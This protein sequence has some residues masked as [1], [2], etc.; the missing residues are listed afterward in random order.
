MAVYFVDSINGS[1][2]NNGLSVDKAFKGF[3]KINET[4]LS[5]G[6]KILLKRGSVFN[7][8][9]SVKSSGEEYAPIEISAYGEDVNK[10]IIDITDDSAYGIGIFGEYTEVS[11]IEVINRRGRYGILVKAEIT[12]AVKGVSVYGCY[13]HDVWTIN[14]LGPRHLPPKS[15]PHDA[16]GICIETNREAPT[17][18]EELRI[19]HNFVENVN[20]TGIWLGGQWNNRFKNTLNW[21]ANRAP[22]MNDPWYP[23]KDVSIS[24]NTVDHAH[25]DGIVGV[26]CV[27]L[28]MEY[29]KV[30]YAN[31]MSRMGNS[32]VAL[33]SM[34]CTGALVQY[35]EVAYTGREYG[36]DGEAFDI[37]QCNIDNIYQ[38]NYSH[39][40]EGGFIL[41]CN[42]C[43]S[44]ESLY[45][46]IIR[47]NLSV[48]D[49][50]KR[51]D[52]LFNFSGPM[53]DI[54]FLNNTIYSSNKKR[55]RLFQLSDYMQIGLPQDL[56]FANNLFYS[57]S[58]DTYDN[59]EASGKLTFK[60]NLIY[61]MPRLPERENII[62][63]NIYT[64]NPVLKGEG[65]VPGSRVEVE[66]FAPLWCSSMLRLGE[67]FPEC[68][69][70]D[71][72][73]N[74]TRGKRYIGTF[75]TKDLNI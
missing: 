56:L 73:G 23:H 52:A 72:L 4:V 5:G 3:E 27:N 49:A 48:N 26:G 8:C 46:N 21:M 68:A 67:Y 16:G 58:A 34:N 54:K 30:F 53:R 74:D 60:S 14:D 38:Y 39:D 47:N 50:T 36:G 55:F 6:D 22:R 33:W 15:W 40:N 41:V 10:P 11:G 7:G 32:N 75:Y 9:L 71:F 25:G 43:N 2:E 12:G 19:E 70:K 20:R 66:D 31:C 64:V 18:Y 62:D 57:E 65:V 51:D 42:G 29:N 28:L 13:V 17:W 44:K 37:D 61:N 24:W 35:N 45:N 59:L 69:E 63:E 1:N